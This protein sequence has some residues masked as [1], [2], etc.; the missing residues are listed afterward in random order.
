MS[1][2]SLNWKPDAEMLHGLMRIAVDRHCSL[3]SVLEEAIAQYLDEQIGQ[4]LPVEDDPIVGLFSGSPDLSD[5]T[6]EILEAGA[7]RENEAGVPCQ[8]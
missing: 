1:E 2:V 6:E 5:R 3:E 4:P 7:N 8:G